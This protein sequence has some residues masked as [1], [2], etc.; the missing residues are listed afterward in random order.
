MFTNNSFKIKFANGLSKQYL[1][2][3][4]VKQG[5]VL[6]PIIL[7]LFI[8]DLV[9][10]LNSSSPGAISI[11]G[12]SINSPLYADGIVVLP[13]S[14]EALQTFL[15]IYDDY[16][17]SWKLHMNMDKSKVVVFNLNGKHFKNI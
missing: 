6:S 11:N 17:K 1:S 8:D 4:G 13:N 3:C 10:K 5:D 12:L 9:K 15:D 2:S 14:K 16:C 7:N